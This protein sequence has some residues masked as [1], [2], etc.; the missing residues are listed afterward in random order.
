M[1]FRW[2]FG[3]R[4][5]FHWSCYSIKPLCQINLQVHLDT[6]R[7]RF[8]MECHL[9]KGGNRIFLYQSGACTSWYEFISFGLSSYFSVGAVPFW[10]IGI[11]WFAIGY[12]TFRLSLLC[13][14]LIICPQYLPIHL[15][16]EFFYWFT[17]PLVFFF[18]PLYL[19]VV[20]F[21]A[22]FGIWL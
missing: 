2:S 8:W 16:S 18:S 12:Q 11:S 17:F 5:L 13:Y 4:N 3:F 15:P 6:L 14:C 9:L 20:K 1:K 7:L 21:M 10:I 22:G 19:I